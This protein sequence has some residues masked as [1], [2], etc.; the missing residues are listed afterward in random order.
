MLKH[1]S[2][3]DV[4]GA[5]IFFTTP[6]GNT[7]Y[8]TLLGGLATLIICTLDALYLV[9]VI[10]NWKLVGVHFAKNFKHLG[11]CPTTRG[12]SRGGIHSNLHRQ[13]K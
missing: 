11:N 3:L 9:Y 10:I 5:P 6:S 2:K 8:Q 7:H 4:F 13:L 1:L 12:I